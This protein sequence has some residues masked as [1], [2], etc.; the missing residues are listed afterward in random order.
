[1]SQIAFG[2]SCPNTHLGLHEAGCGAT[3][4]VM[5]NGDPQPADAKLAACLDEE[6]TALMNVIATLQG[7]QGDRDKMGQAMS[8]RDA[9]DYWQT[10]ARLARVRGRLIEIRG[11]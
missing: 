3:V 10:M 1:M 8:P 6:A 11:Y 2:C 9:L 4:K 7:I 5:S